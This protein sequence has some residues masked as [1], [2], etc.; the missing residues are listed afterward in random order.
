MI[1]LNDYNNCPDTMSI[2]QYV[3]LLRTSPEVLMQEVTGWPATRRRRHGGGL[4]P[5]GVGLDAKWK[6]RC[7]LCNTEVRKGDRIAYGTEGLAHVLCH[8]ARKAQQRVEAQAAAAKT[9]HR[10][11][12]DAK[13]ARRRRSGVA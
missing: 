5:R 9:E 2:R 6:D 8:L 11:K 7:R 3:Y 13:F 1:D 12:R 10:R 4:L